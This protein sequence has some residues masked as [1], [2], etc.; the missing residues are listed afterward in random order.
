MPVH[1][2][3]AALL[4]AA[5]V[6]ESLVFQIFHVAFVLFIIAVVIRRLWHYRVA[7]VAVLAAAALYGLLALF[8]WSPAWVNSLLRGRTSTPA[9]A[10]VQE[11]EV[12]QPPATRTKGPGG[13]EEKRKK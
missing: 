1:C 10:E 3:P 2:S 8:M 6:Q 9:P 13:V 7:V 5:A 11:Q 12:P 4:G